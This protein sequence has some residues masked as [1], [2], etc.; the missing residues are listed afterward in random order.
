MRLADA[1]RSS[2]RE[3]L[4]AELAAAGTRARD[5]GCPPEVLAELLD[6]RSGSLTEDSRS[7]DRE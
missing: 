5:A 2:L 7:R 6:V 3:L 4:I 1:T